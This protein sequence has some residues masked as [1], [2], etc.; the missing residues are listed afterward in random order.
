MDRNPAA[1][2]AVPGLGVKSVFSEFLAQEPKPREPEYLAEYSANE[3]PWDVHRAQADSVTEIYRVGGDEFE[4][5][6]ARINDCSQILEYAWVANE[7][8]LQTG[9]LKFR[10]KN[11]RFCR[12][13]TCPVCQWRRALMWFGRFLKALDKVLAVNPAMS[14]IFMSITVRNCQID[15][16]RST[17]RTMGTGWGRFVKKKEFANIQGWV[18]TTE[19]T[20]GA[21]GTAH[22]HF[23]ILLLVRNSWFKKAYVT[24]EK[25][26]QSWRDSARLDYNPQVNVKKVRGRDFRSAAAETLKYSVKPGD[27]ID[28]PDWFRELTRQIR[29]LRFIAAGGVFKDAFREEDETQQDL[30]LVD[31]EKP[32]DKEHGRVAFNWEKPVQHY[33][34]MKDSRVI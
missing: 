1:I 12:V 3:K 13:R 25:W 34:R 17:L 24:H 19:I 7:E 32:E 9:A 18:R 10:L 21:Q 20:Y 22:P 26:Q 5:L 29:Q 8:T 4:R 14:L 27:A 11:A 2:V 30:L 16:L 15:D 28:N 23:H 33:R 31:E 6:A